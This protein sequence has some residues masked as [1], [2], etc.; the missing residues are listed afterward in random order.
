MKPSWSVMIPAYRCNEFLAQCLDSV[1]VQDPGQEQMQIAVV[2]DDPGDDHC[3]KVVGAFTG[4]RIEYHRN[5]RNLGNG[6]N[7]N[8]CIALASRDLVLILHGD[9][10][11]RE[12]YFERL[13]ALAATNPT[14]GMIACRADGVDER[15]VVNWVSRRYR[16]FETL[17][18]DDSPIWESLHL[19]PS[20]VVVRRKVYEQ[21][22]GFRQDIAN[23][24]DWEMWGR[25]IRAAG[26]IMTPDVLAAYRQHAASITGRTR[27]SAQNIREFGQLYDMFAAGRPNYPIARMRQGLASMAFGQGLEFQRLGDTEAAAANFREWRALTSLPS[28]VVTVLKR[29][30]KK[31]LGRN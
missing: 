1:L 19:M 18:F 16:E 8:R 13:S 21:I 2:N 4:G 29:G 9:D 28:R 17:S 26:I 20:A 5:E 12:H 10:Y 14:A 3:A 15:G 22:G 23:G 27:R 6:G 11:L 7:F 25:V 30:V 31:L 24:Q